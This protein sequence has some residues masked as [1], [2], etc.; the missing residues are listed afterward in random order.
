MDL[1]QPLSSLIPLFQ[2]LVQLGLQ[3][4]ILLPKLLTQGLQGREADG[5]GGGKVREGVQP[6]CSLMMEDRGGAI[7]TPGPNTLSSLHGF[8]QSLSGQLGTQ[9][10]G[11]CG[12]LYA[13]SPS[14]PAMR[15][16]DQES[17][18]GP[19]GLARQRA[20]PLLLFH[21]CPHSVE[22]SSSP[23]LPQ[24]TSTPASGLSL[25]IALSEKSSPTPLPR[26]SEA[27]ALSL[28]T[29]PALT[30]LRTCDEYS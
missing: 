7:A 30:L 24:L 29:A 9:V 5:G 12:L 23:G 1:P 25:N 26:V 8:S 27:T 17:A 20:L 21:C 14:E 22:H 16:P 10:L 18:T 2:A 19:S 6:K 11:P 13:S 15:M 28:L 3:G 4:L